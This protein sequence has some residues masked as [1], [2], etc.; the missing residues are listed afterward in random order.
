MSD[1]DIAVIGA[2]IAGASL[3]YFA[4]PHARVLLL[5]AEDAPG[6]HTTGR[7]AAFWVASYGGPGVLPLTL[8]SR[9]FFDAAPPGFTDVPLLTP[10]GA[11]HLASP[12]DPGA[13]ERLA[14]DF[15]ATAVAFERLGT[16]ALA[17]RYPLLRPAWRQAAL[18]EPDCYD[19]D[20]AALHAG[21]LSGARRAGAVVACRAGVGA[22]TRD[23]QG[24][25]A[26]WRIATRAGEFHAAVVVNAAGAWADAVGALAGAQPLGLRPL[27][28][29]MAVVATAPATDPALPVILDAAGS[30]YFKPDAGRYWVSPHDEI[31]DTA[32]DAAPEELDIA[33][34]VARFEAAVTPR[35]T[36]VE[37]SWAGLRTFAPDRL[38]VYGFD[39]NVPGLFWC[40]GQGGFGIQTAPAAG[41]MAA[42]LVLGREPK[43]EAG[44]YA[45]GRFVSDRISEH[46]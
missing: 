26:R 36:R 6:Y 28:R 17:A 19:I 14:A 21:F 4:A 8:A 43:V 37:R 13:L 10:R 11:L 3:A 30:F 45:A 34:A 22:L 2:G 33:L 1:Y 5:E 12:D 18:Y 42:A 44:R 41:A 9:P 38:P 40:A 16:A 25:D 20:V 27:R 35:V 39:A 7:S 46:I 32:R 15:A 29:T 23:G 24:M 31:A